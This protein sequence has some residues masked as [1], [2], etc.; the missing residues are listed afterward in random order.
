MPET[1]NKITFD[2]MHML[3]NLFK[4]HLVFGAFLRGNTEA[5]PLWAFA[6][7]SV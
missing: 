5:H 7:V 3:P 4:K 2:L 6:F 1:I